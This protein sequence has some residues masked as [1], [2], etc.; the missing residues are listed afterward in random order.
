MSK[1]KDVR[2]G[3]VLKSMAG[4]ALMF[5]MDRLADALNGKSGESPENILAGVRKA[6]DDFADGAEQFDDVTM[7]CLEYK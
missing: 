1:T 6:V 3:I 4:I 2:F 5:G 7:L